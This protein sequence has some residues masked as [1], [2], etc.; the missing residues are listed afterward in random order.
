MVALTTIIFV[1]GL[2][3]LFSLLLTFFLVYGVNDVDWDETMGDS[4]SD[5]K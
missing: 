5:G 1:I 3:A 2:L 4:E